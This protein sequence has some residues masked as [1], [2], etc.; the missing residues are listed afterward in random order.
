MGDSRRRLKLSDAHGEHIHSEPYYE[1]TAEWENGCG[2]VVRYVMGGR[3][4]Q[5][6]GTAAHIPRGIVESATRRLRNQR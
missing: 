5:L 2:D 4:R 6:R 1:W 3:G